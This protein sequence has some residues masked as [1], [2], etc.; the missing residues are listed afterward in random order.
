MRDPEEVAV[1]AGLLDFYSDRATAHASFVVAGMFGI[2]TVVFARA[3]FG[4]GIWS[5]VI[6]IA[7]YIGLVLIDLYSF[8]NFGYYATLAYI[9][10]IKLEGQR[11]E[12]YT[13]EME[14]KLK[15]RSRIFYTFKR[16]KHGRFYGTRRFLGLFCL[17]SIAVILPFVWILW[18]YG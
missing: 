10:R 1:L 3:H 9:V 7:V 4:Q 15:E 6:F 5:L 8:M 13:K 2:Y 16:F 18:F 14:S 11:V 17:W 12:E